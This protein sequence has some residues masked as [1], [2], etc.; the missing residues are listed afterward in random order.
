ME[1]VYYIDLK[2]VKSKQGLFEV[3]GKE[4]ELPEHFGDNLDAFYDVLTESSEERNIIFYN[5]SGISAEIPEY[6]SR[7]LKMC[8]GAVSEAEGALKIRFYN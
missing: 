7:L 3:I 6:Y 5:C 8:K 1:K 4:M 2:N